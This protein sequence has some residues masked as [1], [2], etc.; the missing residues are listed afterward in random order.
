MLRRRHDEEG[1][2]E[3]ENAQ[4]YVG[5]MPSLLVVSFI[6]LSYA[7]VA[8]SDPMLGT[9]HRKLDLPGAFPGYADDCR[10]HFL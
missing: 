2:K 1:E 3:G 5:G 7:L 9:C 4:A 6:G 8:K 10:W